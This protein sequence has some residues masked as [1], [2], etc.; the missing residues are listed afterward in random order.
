MLE[1]LQHVGTP[2]GH[3][4]TRIRKG[5]PACLKVQPGFFARFTDTLQVTQGVENYLSRVGGAEVNAHGRHVV[6]H[7]PISDKPV[8]LSPGRCPF[9]MGVLARTLVY[10]SK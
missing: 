5:V 8:A 1:R 9:K 4:V 2:P 3:L 10:I 6:S 7:L